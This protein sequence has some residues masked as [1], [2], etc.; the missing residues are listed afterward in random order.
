MTQ[1]DLRGELS[2]LKTIVFDQMT[3]LQQRLRD[4]QLA[5]SAEALQRQSSDVY[6]KSLEGVL[7]AIIVLGLCLSIVAGGACALCC[8][9]HCFKREPSMSMQFSEQ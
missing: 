7:G 6:I 1:S 8:T 2:E 9:K 3:M 5:T 4:K